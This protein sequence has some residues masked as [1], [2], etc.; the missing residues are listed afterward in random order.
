MAPRAMRMDGGGRERERSP[1]WDGRAARVATW[2]AGGRRGQPS[3]AP[4]YW[5]GG[6]RAGAGPGRRVALLDRDGVVIHPRL[7]PSRVSVWCSLSS[8]TW[9]PRETARF[10][11]VRAAALA[12]V[13][14]WLRLFIGFWLSGCRWTARA[15]HWV[16]WFYFYDHGGRRSACF[17]R[18]LVNKL[19]DMVWR[20]WL[21]MDGTGV[22][23]MDC[24]IHESELQYNSVRC[25]QRLKSICDTSRIKFKNQ[26][27]AS[28]KGR[29]SSYFLRFILQEF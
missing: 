9:P 3:Q 22:L 26:P 19:C 13:R 8:S 12:C 7:S 11:L 5:I 17:C 14:A 15:A 25:I 18:G 29:N 16:N 21:F 20:F 1:T 23:E 6:A 27:C 24:T 10:C 4:G 2:R 28:L